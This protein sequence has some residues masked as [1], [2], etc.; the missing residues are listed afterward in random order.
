MPRPCRQRNWFFF[1]R[2]SHWDDEKISCGRSVP[3]ACFSDW[4]TE[5]VRILP[6]PAQCR[7]C[8]GILREMLQR[9]KKTSFHDI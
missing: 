3:K 8:H 4:V 7:Y 5:V 6:F 9:T 1:F 2:R